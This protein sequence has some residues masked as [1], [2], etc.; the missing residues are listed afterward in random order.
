MKREVCIRLTLGRSISGQILKYQLTDIIVF[1]SIGAAMAVVFYSFTAVVLI[2]PVLIKYLILLSVFNSIVF[3]FFYA[4]DICSTLKKSNDSEVFLPFNYLLK[5]ISSTLLILL[6]ILSAKFVKYNERCKAAE[7]FQQYFRDY[8][9]IELS[10]S[11]YWAALIDNSYSDSQASNS[12]KANL[13]TQEFEDYTDFFSAVNQKTDTFMLNAFNGY[14]TNTTRALNVVLASNCADKYIEEQTN[15]EL[16]DEKITLLIPD[17]YYYAD[18]N[19]CKKWL[20]E[21]VLGEKYDDMTEIINYK[22]ANIAVFGY[23]DYSEKYISNYDF[24]ILSSPIVIYVPHAEDYSFFDTQQLAVNTD[25]NTAEEILEELN[26]RST[27]L[28]VSSVSLRSQEYIKQLTSI[29][30][31]FILL[32]CAAVVYNASIYFSTVTLDILINRKDRAILKIL[33]RTFI[34]RHFKTYS[35][36]VLSVALSAIAASLLASALGI[37]DLQ[38]VL[39]VSVVMITIDILFFTIIAYMD[40]KKN[41]VKSLK[42]GAL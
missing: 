17:T 16:S 34:F 20:K 26:I 2:I 12:D 1:F 41:T 3:V 40:V 6:V 22:K 27:A 42:G 36:A 32:L 37:F 5:F 18:L 10:E 8:Q 25:K 35:A 28:D 7:E 15:T 14:N 4:V 33:G 13:I 39:I 38:R 29:L 30:V 31:I 9:Y 24:N 23:T 21:D 19:I 11:P